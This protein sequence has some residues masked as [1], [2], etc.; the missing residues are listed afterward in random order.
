MDHLYRAWHLYRNAASPRLD[1]NDCW[2]QI[3]GKQQWLILGSLP[4]HWSARSRREACLLSKIPNVARV[5][6]YQY[7]ISGNRSLPT[8]RRYMDIST[9]WPRP[10]SRISVYRTLLSRSSILRVHRG[11]NEGGELITIISVASVSC[12]VIPGNG[13][14]LHGWRSVCQLPT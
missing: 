9:V 10:G 1:C 12:W 11:A 5:C 8:P 7:E 2:N 3:A 13:L 6:P 14:S 4:F